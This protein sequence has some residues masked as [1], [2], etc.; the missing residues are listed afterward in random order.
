M[1]IPVNAV[2]SGRRKPDQGLRAEIFPPT[3]DEHQLR[4]FWMNVCCDQRPHRQGL[5]NLNDIIAGQL[6]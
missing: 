1:L 6:G 4:G 3:A 2:V 5:A